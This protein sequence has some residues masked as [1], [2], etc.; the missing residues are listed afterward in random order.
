MWHGNFQQRRSWIALALCCCLMGS[1]SCF[2]AAKS[3]DIAGD[4]KTAAPAVKGSGTGKGSA[5]KQLL[6]SHDPDGMSENV[7]VSPAA[8]S[9]E[10]ERNPFE[11]TSELV[12][13]QASP[14]SVTGTRF[15]PRQQAAPAQ[16][17]PKMWLRGHLQDA[18]EEIIALL[19]VEDAGVYIVR[20]GDNVGLHA[21]GV[22]SVLRVVQIDRLQVVVETGSLGKMVIIR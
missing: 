22:D 9:N 1:G 18:R 5:D 11:P 4:D 8:P 15:V 12:Q 20:E 13:V 6:F 17:L 19:E 3:A 21:L 2:A 14:P 7:V 16:Q 10:V